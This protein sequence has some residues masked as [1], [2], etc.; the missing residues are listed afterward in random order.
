MPIYWCDCNRETKRKLLDENE[1]NTFF[2]YVQ[3]VSLMKNKKT[4][5]Q[6]AYF[7]MLV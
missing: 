6:K 5:K 3:E 7:V 2:M 1:T 4:R